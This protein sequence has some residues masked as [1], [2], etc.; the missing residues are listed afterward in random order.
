MTLQPSAEPYVLLACTFEAG[1]A[2]RFA[3]HLYTDQPVA[4]RPIAANEIARN[5][6]RLRAGGGAAGGAA[7]EG[8]GGAWLEDEAATPQPR[9]VTGDGGLSTSEVAALRR[10]VSGLAARCARDGVKYVD[11]EFRAAASSLGGGLGDGGEGGDWREGGTPAAAVHGWSRGAELA[12]AS[13]AGRAAALWTNAWALGGYEVGALADAPLL[14]AANI[15]A[16]DPEL[17][18]RIFV[19]GA[20]KAASL[21]QEAGVC[22]VQLYVDGAWHAYVLDDQLPMRRDPATGHASLAFGRPCDAADLWLPLLEKAV[23]KSLGGYHLLP[24]IGVVEALGL[25]AGAV[26]EELHLA[27][28]S[29]PPAEVE[30]WRADLWEKLVAWLSE[31]RTIGA[32]RRAQSGGGGGGG[33]GGAGAGA[34]VGGSGGGDGDGGGDADGGDGLEAQGLVSGRGYAILCVGSLQG[35]RLLRLRC[36]NDVEF[37]GDWS[38]HSDKW[39]V[40]T[41]QM[42]NYPESSADAKDGFF[43]IGFGDFLAHFNP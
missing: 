17:M 15:V 26:G 23:A 4:L 24:A 3:L 27:P 34:G 37:T 30:A 41:R 31:G 9:L 13:G 39:T 32:W 8:G 43:W 36:P 11:E 7:G 35:E 33:G 10:R 18:E 1:Q 2:A 42:L 40:R 20:D 6:G 22:A 21:L 16:G 12:G 5:L 19:L 38:D 28:P 14:C 25:L 29:G